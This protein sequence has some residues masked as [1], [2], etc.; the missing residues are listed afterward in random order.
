MIEGDDVESGYRAKII[1]LKYKGYTVPWNKDGNQSPYD[2]NIRKWI[3]SI[4]SMKKVLKVSYP[5]NI[6]KQTNHQNIW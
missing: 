1:L 5:E 4:V 2:V 3:H 6:Y